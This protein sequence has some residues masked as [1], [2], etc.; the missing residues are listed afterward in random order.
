METWVL[1][2]NPGSEPATV[3][4]KFLTGSGQTAGPRL[5]LPPQTRAT[6]KVNDTV[7][8]VWDVSTVVSSNVP[9]VAERAEYWDN[10]IE[11]QDSV[12]ADQ[13]ATDWYL[14]EGSTG[15]NFETWVLVQNPGNSPAL[16]DISFMT[17]GGVILGPKETLPPQTRKS[18]NV[19]KWCQDNYQVATV[20]H[21]SKPVVVERS[22]YGNQN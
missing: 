19:A 9:V 6:V 17:L 12:G 5:H 10:R 4:L 3:D 11:G 2:E 21:A 13:P 20:V 8:N 1:V 18:Y 22:V 16:V 15:T 14:A 7:A